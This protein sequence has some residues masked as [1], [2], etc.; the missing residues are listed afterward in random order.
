MA[1][2]ARNGADI[3]FGLIT[4][5]SGASAAGVRVAKADGSIPLYKALGAT[6]TV[7]Q[8]S[9]FRIP[10][11]MLSF[12]YPSGDMTDAHMEDAIKPYW[13]GVTKDVDMMA[14]ANAAVTAA[15]YAQQAVND[16]DFDKPAD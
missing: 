1:F 7:T 8:N 5:A 3:L 13:D 12:T 16:W 10:E 9:Q 2:R 11:H 14:S 4:A 15:G 6:L